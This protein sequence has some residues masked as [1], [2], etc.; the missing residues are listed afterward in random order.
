MPLIAKLTDEE[1]GKKNYQTTLNYYNQNI[2]F[3]W[4][5]VFFKALMYSPLAEIN[6]YEGATSK[7]TKE[8]KNY[9]YKLFSEYVKEEEK[10]KGI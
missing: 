4:I 2:N 5:L 8:K 7:D 1:I 3:N 6:K 9:F 10:E